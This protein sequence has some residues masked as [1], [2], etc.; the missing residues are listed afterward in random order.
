MR[1]QRDMFPLRLFTVLLQ[2]AV[3]TTQAAT[4]KLSHV[5]PMFLACIMS[6]IHTA[7]QH[8]SQG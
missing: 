5:R 1:S 4:T 6:Y 3:K 8:N 2:G 7:A